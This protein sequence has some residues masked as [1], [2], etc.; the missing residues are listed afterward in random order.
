MSTTKA[1]VHNLQTLLLAAA[2]T[3]NMRRLSLLPRLVI[4][5]MGIGGVAMVYLYM[6]PESLPGI[7]RVSS[8]THTM[9][10]YGGALPP[11]LFDLGV[12]NTG[13]FTNE[14]GVRPPFWWSNATWNEEDHSW[15]WG[16]CYAPFTGV[17]WKN[18]INAA[19]PDSPVYPTY[20]HS[21]RNEQD[22]AG[23]CRP[24][25]LIIGAGKCGTRYVVGWWRI[26]YR[27]ESKLQGHSS[28]DIL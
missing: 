26:Y 7:D 10:V 21:G 3:I 8:R 12:Y 18:E 19:D 20:Q 23:L 25:F 14:R 17:H 11:D 27:V 6:A 1:L 4:I 5:A 22:V 16:P 9:E 28:S 2:T 24:S 13:D 15:A